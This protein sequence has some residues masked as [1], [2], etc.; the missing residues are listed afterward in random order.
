MDVGQLGG[1]GPPG[2]D[3]DQCPGWI[4]RDVPEGEPRVREAV[5]LPGILADEDRDLT[6][7]EV[8][9]D[10]G[11][12]H[13]PVHPRLA[14]LLLCDGAGAELRPEGPE[15]RGAVEAAQVIA[16]A[17][18]PVIEDGLAAVRIA[19]GAE[20]CRPLRGSRGPVDRLEGAVGA[21]AQG[22][23]HPL[24]PAVLIV[25]EPQRLLAGVA[26]GRRMRLVTA[27]LLEAAAI[28][29][30]EPDQDAAVALAED[31][32]AGAPRRRRV[33]SSRGSHRRDLPGRRAA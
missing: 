14:R 32:G 7:L 16:L 29:S 10:G 9:T 24:T 11:A 17:A 19:H 15:G 3:H 12:E 8:A 23:E 28:L 13:E 21:A 31:A 30:A 22:M 5:R 4:P 26:L 25:I 18:A 20:P 2:V 33:G 6:V 1:F 27:D